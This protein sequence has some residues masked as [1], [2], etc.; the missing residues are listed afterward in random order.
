VLSAELP[1]FKLKTQDSQ[2]STLFHFL[3]RRVL[4]AELAELVTFQPI[5]IVLLVFVRRIIPLLAGRT[6][7]INDFTHRFLLD[8]G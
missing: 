1:D 8:P 4:P 6:G 3:M 5:R 7:Q 2:L